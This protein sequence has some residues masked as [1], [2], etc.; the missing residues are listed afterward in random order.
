MQSTQKRRIAALVLGERLGLAS[1]GQRLLVF[2]LTAGT[3]T[4]S[5]LPLEI[6]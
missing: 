4:L 6:V 5:A 1:I 3:L 2:A